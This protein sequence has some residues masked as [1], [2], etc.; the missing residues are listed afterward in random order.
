MK[1][2]LDVLCGIYRMPLE[3]SAWSESVTAYHITRKA[4]IESIRR[5]GISAKECQATLY[6][7]SRISAVYLMACK[8]DANDENVRQFLFGDERDLTVVKVRIPRKAY[9]LMRDDGLFN[10][11]CLCKDGSYPTA[12]QFT[13]DIPADWI[14]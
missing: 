4:N 1:Y 9:H 3:E 14:I 10:M 13:G 12:I 11:S 2:D 5:T 7:N 8:A 6:G